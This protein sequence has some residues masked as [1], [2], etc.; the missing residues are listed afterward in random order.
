MGNL[1]IDKVI[2]GTA[3]LGGVWGGV[4]PKESIQAIHEALSHGIRAL[5]TAPAYGDAESIVGQAL[6]LWT[7]E[8]PLISTKVGRLKSYVATEA[9]YDYSTA[10]MQR[11][12]DESLKTLGVSTVDVLFL[13]EP[14]VLTVD[15][16]ERVISAIE[17]FKEQG[18]AKKIG[19]GGNPPNW[20]LPF[21]K[22]GRFDI[23]MEYNKLNACSIEALQNSIPICRQTQTE[24]YAASPLNMGLLGCKFQEFSQRIPEWLDVGT[25]E[26]AR[27]I[28]AIAERHNLP[29]EVLALRFLLNMN[30]VFKIVLGAANRQQLQNSLEAI[31]QGVLPVNIYNEILQTFND[32]K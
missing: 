27:R 3:G 14:A 20:F 30:A 7:G 19:I 16:A 5:D 17:H 2:L 10:G 31:K 22:E 23:V 12:V 9:K 15:N 6:E 1:G 21:L 18:L 11:S 29:L 13:H 26:Q 4:D 32:N 28:Q 8:R 24:Y 25:V